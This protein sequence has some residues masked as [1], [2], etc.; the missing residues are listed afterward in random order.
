MI[1]YII[2]VSNNFDN[3]VKVAQRRTI[4]GVDNFIKTLI[5]RHQKDIFCLIDKRT[6][7]KFNCQIIHPVS[8]LVFY[9][10]VYERHT[11]R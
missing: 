11:L 3:T 9:V 2:K 8:N 1:S 6:D 4:D 7:N 5:K 10:R